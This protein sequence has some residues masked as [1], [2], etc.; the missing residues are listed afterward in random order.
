MS[1]DHTAARPTDP[2]AAPEEPRYLGSGPDQAFVVWHPAAR[3]SPT[4]VILCPP[5]GWEEVSSYRPRRA[6]AQSLAAAGHATL[7]VTLPSTGDSGGGARDAAR[8]EAWT[9]TV[10]MAAAWVRAETRADRIVALGM[11]LGGMLAYRCAALGADIDDLVLWAVAARGRTLVRQLRAMSRLEQA[12]FFEG[13]QAPPPSAP[14]E[15][16]VTGFVLGADTVRDLEALD[17]PSLPLPHPERRRVLVLG[18]DGV[19]D[20]ALLTH[21]SATGVQLETGPGRGYG[22]MTSHPQVATAADPVLQTVQTWLAG[23]PADSVAGRPASGTS[24]PPPS[25]DTLTGDGWSEVPIAVEHAGQ[26][27]AGIVAAPATPVAG[28]VCAV[29]LNTG[30]VRRTGPNRMWVEAARRW[31]ARGVPSLRVD[32]PGIGDADG[33]LV[34]YADDARFH[35]PELLDQLRSALDDLSERGLGE[36]FLLVGLCSGAYWAFRTGLDDPRVT[37]LALLNQRV[38][39]WDEGLAASRDI[40][41]LLTERPSLR[42]FR[43]AVT[44]HRVREVLGWLLHASVRILRRAGAGEPR[45]VR[46]EDLLERLRTSGTRATYL[47]AEREPLSDELIRSGWLARLEQTGNATVQRLAVADHTLRPAW[48]QGRAHEVLDAALE[49]ELA[50]AGTVGAPALR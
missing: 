22:D 42:R 3:P 15:L 36:R 28:G 7:R 16:E 9:A 4:A 41:R 29:L 44:A 8:L 2:P 14:G 34:A 39:V 10:A 27:L 18:R 6:W 37:G 33:P 47:F 32:L 35:E 20:Q 19:V 26:R 50:S 21:L 45:P 43:R 1:E 25:Q 13:L 40:R 5:V 38:V 17:L 11:G 48:A 30:S 31:A 12:Q 46:S 49:R 23:A 24:P